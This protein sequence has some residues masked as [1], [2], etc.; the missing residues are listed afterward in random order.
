MLEIILKPKR[1]EEHITDKR[2]TPNTQRA[3]RTSSYPQ[4]HGDTACGQKSDGLGV[5]TPGPR[6]RVRE[7]ASLAVQIHRA[8]DLPIVKKVHGTR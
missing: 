8:L 6:L 5:H 2:W 1:K 7:P 4:R 3:H